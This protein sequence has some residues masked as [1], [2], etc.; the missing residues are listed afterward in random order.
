MNGSSLEENSVLPGAVVRKRCE[1]VTIFMELL[2]LVASGNE[3]ENRDVRNVF[4]GWHVDVWRN[5]VS[6]GTIES[7]QLSYKLI[8]LI[9]F[10]V[11]CHMERYDAT[12]HTQ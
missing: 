7:S 5:N 11:P 12:N 3:A 6:P 8:E 4:C 9:S 2:V 10:V 1:W